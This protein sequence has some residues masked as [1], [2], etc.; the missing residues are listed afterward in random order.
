VWY[1]L[2][3]NNHTA[4]NIIY[5]VML[6]FRTIALCKPTLEREFASR[7]I[8][9]GRRIG[10]ATI[11]HLLSPGPGRLEIGIAKENQEPGT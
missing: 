1:A 11:K 3:D 2:E 8:M 9:D 4:I 7:S 6:L 5:L 10:I